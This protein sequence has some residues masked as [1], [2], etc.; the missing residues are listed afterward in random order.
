MLS[1]PLLRYVLHDEAITRG[2]GDE[3]ARVLIEW[4]VEWAELLADELENEQAAWNSMMTLC[5]LARGIGRFVQLW[6]HEDSRGAAAQLAAVERFRWPLP[7]CDEDPADLMF[8]ILKWEDR[9]LV[10]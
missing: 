6:S 8:R 5:Q 10:F 7:V 4:L 2:L 3:E 1:S 9:Q